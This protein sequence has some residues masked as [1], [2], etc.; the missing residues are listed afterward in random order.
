MVLF[1]LVRWT[2]MDLFCFDEAVAT[3]LSTYLYN[4]QALSMN[5]SAFRPIFDW[6]DAWCIFIGEYESSFW[7][8]SSMSMLK[9]SCE[10]FAVHAWCLFELRL[11]SV[12]KLIILILSCWWCES[13]V[14]SHRSFW[15]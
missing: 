4:S 2:G 9:R 5:S 7:W 8:K 13:A 15:V 11:T 14:V 12:K 6:A 10:K 3:V 1:F